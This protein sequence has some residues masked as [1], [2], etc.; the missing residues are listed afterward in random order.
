VKKPLS[1][2]LLSAEQVKDIAGDL[3]VGMKVFINPDTLEYKSIPD[4]EDQGFLNDD[5]WDEAL[6]VIENEWDSF[7]LIEKMSSRE[8]FGIMEDFIEEIDD[9]AYRQ[10]LS[11]ILG[12]RSPFANFKAEVESSDFRQA[13]FDFRDQRYL[14]YVKRHLYEE[15]IPFE[16]EDD[17]DSGIDDAEN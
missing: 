3:Q 1:E 15:D 4:M 5:V 11:K 16:E 6:E 8:A 10:E 2:N 12:R 9:K 13:W 17:E 14:D 7:V